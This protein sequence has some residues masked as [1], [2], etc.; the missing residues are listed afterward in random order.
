MPGHRLADFGTRARTGKLGSRECTTAEKL[1]KLAALQREVDE[2]RV[3]LV[4]S[5]QMFDAGRNSE[6]TTIA[7]MKRHLKEKPLDGILLSFPSPMSSQDHKWSFPGHATGQQSIQP[8]RLCSCLLILSPMN[9]PR[10]FSSLLNCRKREK[11]EREKGE[12][13]LRIIDFKIT[14]SPER[15][16]EHFQKVATL[17]LLS[18]MGL[19]SPNQNR[20]HCNSG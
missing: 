4:A 13:V 2:K 12:K 18:P 8:C 5:K 10:D 7:K 11:K 17:N 9:P 3:S 20:S 19:R 1:H 14:L 16:K 15:M 6:P